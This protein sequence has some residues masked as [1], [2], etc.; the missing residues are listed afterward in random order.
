MTNLRQPVET[1]KKYV[2]ELILP[3]QPLAPKWNAENV[4]FRKNPKWNYI[5]NCMMT[6][7]LMLY[8][9]TG[10]EELLAYTERFIR[11]YMDGEGNIPT[12]VFSDYN[13]DNING[14]K[15]L[16]KLYQLTGNEAYLSA[17]EKLVSGQLDKQ[18]RLDCGNFWHKAIYPRQIW[19]DGTYM[20]LP[21]MAGCSALKDE[22]KYLDDV[23]MQLKNIRDIMRDKDSGLYHHGYDE[24]RSM[25]WADPDTGLSDEFWLR[26]MGWLCAALAD[27][28]EMF[29]EKKLF[30]DMLGNLLTALMRTANDDGT[31]M[32]LPARPELSGNYPETSGTLL[33]AYSA[34]KSFRLGICGSSIGLAG[35]KALSAVSEKFIFHD[36]SG[37][38]VLRNICLM[39]G[40]GSGR[41]GS[42]EYYLSEK[43]VENDAKGIAPFLMACNELIRR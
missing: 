36:S 7:L 38:P 34:L 30:S 33:F 25:C 41:D 15:N 17:A 40:L 42:A 20:A 13:L 27:L 2:R 3:S 1:A 4:I 26:S 21:F 28:S 19:L 39:A 24:T 12:L 29:P 6:A 43:I 32:Q 37:V 35:E 18:P 10:N 5:D 22:P 23:C 31:L 14:G 16:I 11:A 9:S 8:E